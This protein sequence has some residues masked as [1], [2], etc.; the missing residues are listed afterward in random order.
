MNETGKKPLLFILIG[1]VFIVIGI[2]AYLIFF[3]QK[4]NDISLDVKAPDAVFVGENNTIKVSVIGDN[5]SKTTIIYKNSLLSSEKNEY[6]GNDFDVPFI[7][8]AAGTEEVEI[9]T[10]DINKKI[11]VVICDKLKTLNKT[12]L[13]EAGISSNLDFGVPNICLEKYSFKIENENV[14]SYVDGS[15][16][17]KKVGTTSLVISRGEE[18]YN[19]KI[20][21]KSATFSFLSTSSTIKTG[22]EE[23]IMLKGLNGKHTCKSSDSTIVKVEADN[24]SCLVKGIKEGEAKITASAGGKKVSTKVIVT[25]LK[26]YNITFDSNGG[27]AVVSQVLDPGN[28]VNKPNNPTKTG[29]TFKE[30]QLSGRPYDF[31]KTVTSDLTLT[32]VWTAN[33]YTVIYDANGGTG[34]MA[35]QVMTYGNKY[36]LNANTFTK[37]GYKF[38]GWNGI[39]YSYELEKSGTNEYLQNFDMAPYFNKYGTDTTYHLEFDMKSANTSKNNVIEVYSYQ[40]SIAK[41]YMVG[42][43]KKYN[44]TTSYKHFSFDF[45]VGLNKNSSQNVTYLSFFGNYSTGN[46]PHVKN[47][48]LSIVPSLADKASVSN[49]TSVA[50]GKVKLYANW[51]SNTG[52]NVA[53]SGINL[54]KSVVH[55][56]I[57]TT[58]QLVASVT[59]TNA[60]N[61]S[62]IWESSNPSVVSVDNGTVK[63]LKTGTATITAKSSDGRKKATAF[64]VA[65]T[66]NLSIRYDG[67]TIKYSVDNGISSKYILSYIWVSDAYKQFKIGHPELGT[68]APVKDI[69]T[70]EIRKNNFSSKAIIAVNGSDICTE[71]FHPECVQANPTWKNTTISPILIVD[72]TVIRKGEKSWIPNGFYTNWSINKNSVLSFYGS[73]CEGVANNMI[74]DGVKNNG[75]FGPVLIKNS[76]LQ[77]VDSTSS[78]QRTGLCQIDKYN[79]VILTTQSGQSMN[80]S[81]MQNVFKSIGCT[82]AL[83]IDGGGSVTLGYKLPSTS[84]LNLIRYN[85]GSYGR[86]LADSVYFVGN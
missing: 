67:S 39:L 4:P 21:V 69:I 45:K 64:V 38:N 11:T 76:S 15:I 7:A 5:N 8:Q 74:N 56:K 10:N 29:Y 1:I 60:T 24:N 53:V 72:G 82:N 48:K 58:V 28:Y 23:R 33:Q 59:P 43:A 79:Y 26:R 70:N 34:N 77:N 46:V 84:S 17:A 41:Y 19:Y 63:A 3:G 81:E 37:S 2:A 66:S 14:A 78:A 13:V 73:C 42:G 49:L 57:D 55:L 61:K 62:V 80:Y 52:S 83:N 50:G 51:I 25:N 18:T 36:S 22:S 85:E 30:W 47:L 9:K 68:L 71:R 27:T 65:T 35:S 86:S 75:F 32:A 6:I 31:N 44:V 20:K 54:D 40:P 12:I 16:I